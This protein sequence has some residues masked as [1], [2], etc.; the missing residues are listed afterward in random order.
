V[1][2]SWRIARIAGIDVHVHATFLLLLGWV[3]LSSY[4]R[5]RSPAGA[6]AGVGFVLLI[7]LVV[8][9]HE[10]GHALAAR[11][12]GI[13]TRDITLLPIGGVARL[14]RMPKEPRQ[15]LVVALAGPAVNVVLALVLWIGLRAL[16][17]PDPIAPADDRFLSRTL[18]ERLLSVNVWLAGFNLIPAFPM[19]GGRVLRAV[20]AMRSGNHAR[21]T[22]QAARV[23]RF[24]ALI[25][26]LVGLFVVRN[27]MLVFVALFV[28]LAA[29][30]EANAVQEESTL[31]GVALDR[32]MI[33]D[34]RTIE[35][36]QPL[37]HVVGLILAGFQQDFPVMEGGVIVGVLTR[38]DFLRALGELGEQAPVRA[39]MRR[40]F[41]VATPDEPV[42]QALARLQVCGCHALPVVRGRELLGL[43]TLDNV[44]EYV[45]IRAALQRA[46]ASA[47]A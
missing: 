4:Q 5:T 18:A 37:S 8:L 17:T 26:G 2:W 47:A 34:V 40:D 38:R 14:E 9:L 25:F 30:G 12:Y 35:P 13:P 28:W 46:G 31:A 10:Y 22:A 32:V 23:G 15:E 33:T 24:F 1:K 6:L 41:Q 16:G 42:E 45:M 44:G 39:A 11:R 36:E 7:F 21:A 3:G 43:L 19:D 20:L 29:A 27:P